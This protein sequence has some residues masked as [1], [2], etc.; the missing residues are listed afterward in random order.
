MEDFAA[1][2]GIG[3]AASC[4]IGLALNYYVKQRVPP[5]RVLALPFRET[6]S[7]ILVCARTQK[8]DWLKMPGFLTIHGLVGSQTAR[9]NCV[10]SCSG[11]SRHGGLR[12]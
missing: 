8:S 10:R 1:G 9:S 6:Y 4:S 7:I 12:G 11:Q 2:P 3:R 5:L